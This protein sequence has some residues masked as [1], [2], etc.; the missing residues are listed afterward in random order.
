MERRAPRRGSIAGPTCSSGSVN[1]SVRSVRIRGALVV[2]VLACVAAP[3]GASP[4]RSR[5][6]K[7]SRLIVEDLRYGPA[8]T[9]LERALA[10]AR[11]EDAERIDAYRLLGQAY[12]ARGK[13][14]SAQAA[15]RALLELDPTYALD[16][17]LSPKIREVFGRARADV[18]VRPTIGDVTAIP[19]GRRVVVSGRVT[20]PGAMLTAVDLYTRAGGPTF[21]RQEMVQEDGRVQA[22]VPVPLLDRLRVD[23]YLV[24][25]RGDAPLVAVGD[26][27]SPLSV[28][29]DRPAPAA[30]TAV[31]EAPSTEASAV[32]ETWWFWTAVGVVIVGGIVTAAV[33]TSS[34]PAAPPGTLDPIRL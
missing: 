25:R 1:G 24:G 12:V 10:D 30:P 20:D 8:I 5:I 11:I 27:A 29:V 2:V 28:I 26:A 18:V 33:L 4:V 19:E 15:F 6:T 7:A 32:Y 13:N 23:Y 3:A 14:E 34:D 21:E 17:R 22:V 16:P 31:V 9:I